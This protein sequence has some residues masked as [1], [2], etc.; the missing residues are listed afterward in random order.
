[1]SP[2]PCFLLNYFHYVVGIAALVIYCWVINHP[3]FSSRDNSLLIICIDSKSRALDKAEWGGFKENPW[4]RPHLERLRNGWVESW[5]KGLLHLH[6]W[7]DKAQSLGSAETT[8]QGTGVSMWLWLLQYGTGFWEAA[9]PN[10]IL[11]GKCF[12]RTRQK[13]HGLLW[14]SLW[15]PKCHFCPSMAF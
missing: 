5:G 14:P 3:R 10:R 2:V 8:D 15:I 9:S 11:R 6:V 1:M 4:L 13:L 12:L 7:A